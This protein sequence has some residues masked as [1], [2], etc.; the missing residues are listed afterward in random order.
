LGKWHYIVIYFRMTMEIEIWAPPTISTDLIADKLNEWMRVH[1]SKPP[2]QRLLQEHV[3]SEWP[4]F[5]HLKIAHTVLLDKITRKCL[6]VDEEVAM[7]A[8][9][10]SICHSPLLSGTESLECSHVFHTMCLYQWFRHGKNTCPL[11]RTPSR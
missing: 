3:S 9:I 4:I 10:C 5:W 2:F 1:P 7:D 11:C 6:A 8:E